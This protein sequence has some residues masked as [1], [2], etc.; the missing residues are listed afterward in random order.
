[1]AEQAL[2]SHQGPSFIKQADKQGYRIE[3]K[4]NALEIE[5][6]FPVLHPI[7]YGDLSGREGRLAVSRDLRSWS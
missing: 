3:D 1:M 7:P 6:V 4:F 2:A 5:L